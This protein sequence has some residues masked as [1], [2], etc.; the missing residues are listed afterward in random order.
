MPRIKGFT[1]DQ[2]ADFQIHKAVEWMEGR[3][4][5][6]HL[7]QTVLGRNISVSQAEMS[8]RLAGD[9]DISLKEFIILAKV[10]EASDEEILRMVKI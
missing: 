3:R 8:K 1:N 7:N 5:T 6:K 9:R 2:K 4:K 10:L